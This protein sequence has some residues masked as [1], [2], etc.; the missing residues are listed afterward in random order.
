M[1]LNSCQLDSN[2]IDAST[3]HTAV[4]LDP[5]ETK[6]GQTYWRIRTAGPAFQQVIIAKT[7]KSILALGG[8]GL[9]RMLTDR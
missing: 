9:R 7:S 8:T 1:V 4:A 3:N 5:F 2:F 6:G